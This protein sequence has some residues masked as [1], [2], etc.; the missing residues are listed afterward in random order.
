MYRNLLPAT[1]FAVSVIVSIPSFAQDTTAI[2]SK[3]TWSYVERTPQFKGGDEAMFRFLGSAI[4]VPK[5]PPAG[6]VVLSFIVEVDGSVKDAEVV[7]S[8]SPEV[9]TACIQAIY[10]MSGKWEPGMQNNKLVP[11]R[12]TIPI[13]IAP[14]PT[15][16]K[17]LQA[18][19]IKPPPL[20][21][22][23]SRGSGFHEKYSI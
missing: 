7:Q 6:R 9:D 2:T 3:E 14:A 22:E 10:K 4:K 1:L 19:T 20:P 8:L 21:N 12:F 15:K 18:Y 13:D 16:K 23:V 11:V 17:K 5:N